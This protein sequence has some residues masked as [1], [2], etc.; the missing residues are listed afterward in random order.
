MH[1]GKIS[2][3]WRPFWTLLKKEALRFLVVPGQTLLAPM[4]TATL[5]LFIFG[6]NL[7]RR[8]DVHSSLSYVQFVVPGLALMGIINNAFANTSSSL[9][10]SRYIGNIVDL[11]VTP[12]TATQIIL[13]YT[14]AAILRG[15]MVGTAVLAIS[16]CFTSL[17]WKE[18]VL[19][20]AMA[21]LT[22]FL[23]SQLGIIAAIYSESFEA[24]A[25]YS[26]FLLMPLVYLG[27]L[28]YPTTILPPFWQKIS[29]FN[30]LF[31]S[32]DGFRGAVLGTSDVPIGLCF[33]VTGV[34]SAALF[35]WAAVLIRT[36]HRLRV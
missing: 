18:P 22:S 7:G 34:L 5:F 30:P 33:A 35:G 29:Q 36:G 2:P 25:A 6:I 10:F 15:M 27:G 12:L 9:F 11:L 8:I 13:A 4:V 26:N 16:A 32:I 19:A 31:Y 24:I 1:Q 28:F 3:T 23:L 14:L 20:A 21:I 17:P